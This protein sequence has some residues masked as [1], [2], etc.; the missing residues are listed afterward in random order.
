MKKRLRQLLEKLAPWPFWENARFEWKMFRLRSRRRSQLAQT[1]SL[2]N[3]LVNLGAGASG[4]EGWVNLD[5]FPAPGITVTCD[6]RSVLPL[7]DASARAIF[8]EHFLEHINYD[9]DVPALLADCLRVLQ[10]GGVMRI[11]VPDIERY[12]RAY[13]AEGWEGLEELR[14]VGADHRDPYFLTPLRTKMEL[15]NLLFRQMGEHQFAYD[16]ETLASVLAEAGFV[17]IERAEFGRSR[18]EG[19]AI[20]NPSRAHE[21]LYVEAARPA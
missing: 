11:I 15:V 13:C 2:Q 3:S 7:P 10:P 19:L 21:S 9:K 18:L 16:H 12:L 1:A 17:N 6:C 20:D 5:A 14:G 4:K 8:T